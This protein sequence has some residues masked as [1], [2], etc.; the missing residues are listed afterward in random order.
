MMR[1]RVK[2]SGATKLAVI[3]PSASVRALA[4]QSG[5]VMKLARTRFRSPMA[6]PTGAPPPMT[7]PLLPR[8]RAANSSGSKPSKLVKP[9]T[10]SGNSAWKSSRGSGVLNFMR[11]ST[12]SSTA[13]SV[14]SAPV[15]AAPAAS[16]TV[17]DT[18]TVSPGRT[19]VLSG[20]SV[21]ARSLALLS[22]F[23]AQMPMR[24]SGILSFFG[25]CALPRMT[26]TLMNMFG[27]SAS[28]TGM[29]MTGF[30]SVTGAVKLL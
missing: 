19:S 26:M 6:A 2:L 23:K 13:K 27:A 17:A 16:L 14:T 3:L 12:P 20:F 11:L 25:L 8:S 21:M 10:A 28:V 24:Y 4:S 5:V 7:K 30:S 15:T 18:A 9:S 1:K 29:R 22:T